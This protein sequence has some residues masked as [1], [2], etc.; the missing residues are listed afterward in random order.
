M[1]RLSQKSLD[2]TTQLLHSNM[3]SKKMSLRGTQYEGNNLDIPQTLNFDEN[4]LSAN[5][6]WK[7]TSQ[8]S[9]SNSNLRK[10]L[11]RKSNKRKKKQPFNDKLFLQD[12]SRPWREYY[13][14]YIKKARSLSKHYQ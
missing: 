9:A 1:G 14:K 13:R 10:Y 2:T 8:Q 4:S 12:V 3:M 7:V 11:K 6:S 5:A